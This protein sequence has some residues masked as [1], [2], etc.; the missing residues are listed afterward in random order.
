MFSTLSILSLE[1]G[2]LYGASLS[3]G[4][5]YRL[6]APDFRSRAANLLAIRIPVA[7]F[8]REIAKRF[9]TR[10]A[11]RRRPIATESRPLRP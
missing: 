1:Q 5:F 11:P 2:Q 9:V 10:S 6:F 7:A 3:E 8:L 4:D